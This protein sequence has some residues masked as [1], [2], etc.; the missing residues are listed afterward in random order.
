MPVCIGSTTLEADLCAA[1]ETF[2]IRHSLPSGFLARL[3]WQESLFDPEAVSYKGAL[4]IA[5]FMPG[6][7]R[8]RGL[9]DPFNPPDALAKSA[10][11]LAEL[12]RRFGSLGL[13][14]AA[15]NG[16]E[17][18]V[19]RLLAGAASRLPVE[20]ED[21]VLVITGRTVAEWR[22]GSTA[23]VDFDLEAGTPFR[24]A[25]LTLAATRELKRELAP[26]AAWRPWGV[27]LG[28]HFSRSV[29]RRYF[30]LLKARYP[31]LLGEA[32]AL[33]VADRKLS[34]GPRIRF[35]LRVGKDSRREAYLLCG[36]LRALGGFCTV[37]RN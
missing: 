8:L 9:A 1:I 20:T 35:A 28:S 19:E 29:A 10:A 12:A 11:Y 4:G 7:A 30:R 6:T 3:I 16:G 21:Y 26:Q 32:E 27:H 23:T 36:R 14:A 34:R 37:A 33:I 15:Y 2:A 17:N 13:A 18:R 5:Q 25:C 24:P 31:S 22:E